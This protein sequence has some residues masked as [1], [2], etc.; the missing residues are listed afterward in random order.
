MKNIIVFFLAFFTSS[1]LI[2]HP[3]QV[4]NKFAAPGKFCTGV[5]FDGSKLW[6]ADYKADLLFALDPVT[7]E[8]K[9]KIPSPGFWP[10]DLA[11]DGRFL[12]NIDLKQKKIFQIDPEN[13]QIL[14][15]LD[16]PTDNPGGLTWD[17]K[18]LWV[19]DCKKSKIMKIDIN[20]GTAVQTIEGPALSV[21]GLTFD[22]KYLWSSDR[23]KDEIYMID[24]QKGEVIT[25][26]KSPGKYAY[27][28][29]WDGQYLWNVDQQSDS[30]YQIVCRDDQ[31]YII[32]NTRSAIITITHEVKSNGKG[33]IKD[34]NTYLAI[35][36]DMN[37]QK[38]KSISFTPHYTAE[39]SDKWD[40]KVAMFSY[41]NIP[42]DSVVRS[43]IITE[44]EISDIHYFIFPDRCGT[45][46]DIPEKIKKTYTVDGSK[47][48]MNDPYIQKLSKEVVGDEQNSYWIARK[49][50]NF[51]RDNLEYALEGGWN[52]A[53]VVLKRGTGSCSEYAFSFIS[54]ARA[55]GL[56]AR[57]VGAVVVRGDDASFDEVFHRWPEIYL[58]NYGW[59][60][61]DP[62]GGDKPSPGDQARGIGHLSNR[63]LITT[64]GGGDSEYLGWYYNYNQEY[65]T[66]PQVQVNIETFGE[67]EPLKK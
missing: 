8:T 66:D 24:P 47:Y 14:K 57:Y 58:P 19:G 65:K 53:P 15:T 13:G 23:L 56:P 33:M 60:P 63:F 28:M 4:I 67:W 40:Q 34:L 27:G 37:Q 62:Q 9:S 41:E 10:Q 25:I 39:K 5:A 49:I 16:S 3:G 51:V 52:V 44:A 18:T 31:N 35:P 36:F 45:I 48:L 17:G 22:G 7:G 38:I 12:W 30:V 50:F 64:Q 21:Q 46:N 59:I 32:S 29:A 55:A 11:W 43:M 26:L 1:S 54:L 42:A 2:A 20:D 61:I 6:V